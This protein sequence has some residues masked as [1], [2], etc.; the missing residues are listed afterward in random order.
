MGPRL[1]LLTGSPCVPRRRGRPLVSEVQNQIVRPH[2]LDFIGVLG[3]LR[4]EG[5]GDRRRG[6]GPR[7]EGKD[8][9]RPYLRSRKTRSNDM[10]GDGTGG[11]RGGTDDRWVGT[12]VSHTFRSSKYGVSLFY[13]GEPDKGS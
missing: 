3:D 11:S 9:R 7:D 4:R 12:T 2:R 5:W 8:E 13:H 10:V 6:R 1:G